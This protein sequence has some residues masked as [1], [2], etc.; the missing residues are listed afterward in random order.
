MLTPWTPLCI[1][2]ITAPKV[3]ASRISGIHRLIAPWLEVLQ[4]D[5]EAPLQD[6]QILLANLEEQLPYVWI[7]YNRQGEVV[8][9]ACLTQ[10]VPG[11]HAY[12]HGVRDVEYRKHPALRGLIALIFDTAFSDLRLL[13]LK[14]EFEADNRGALGFCRLYGF[15][16][17]AHFREDIHVQGQLKDVVVYSLFYVTYQQQKE[18]LKRHVIRS[19]IQTTPISTV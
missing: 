15:T 16:R 4:A 14:A 6:P 11:R 1:E 19:K 7:V 17:E 3:L 12:I 5:T 13:K 9:S 18:A 2:Q 8:A 10:V